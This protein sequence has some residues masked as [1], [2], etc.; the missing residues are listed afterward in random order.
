MLLAFPSHTPQNL[1]KLDVSTSPK[2][3]SLAME[4]TLSREAITASLQKAGF[5]QAELARRLEVSSQAVTNWLKGVDFPRPDKLLKLATLL[6]LSFDQLVIQPNRV[7]PVVAFRKKGGAKTTLA[8]IARAQEMGQMLKPLVPYL[9]GMQTLRSQIADPSINY[10]SLQR[11]V[12]EV[13]FKLG[14][15]D[16]AVLEY[17]HLI[18]QFKESGAVLIPVLWGEK[19]RHENALHIYLPDE[20]VTFIFL[21]LD[22]SM[23]DFKFWMAHELA[24]VFT[25]CLAGSEAGED[26]ADAFAG[27]LLFPQSCAKLAYQDASRA[28]TESGIIQAL[29]A[30]SAKYGISLYSVFCETN[31]F[32]K[33]NQLAPLNVT[34]EHI[35]AA[36]F[37]VRK[38][39]PLI[40]ES[41]FDPLPPNP[42]EYIN[43]A[44]SLFN[45]EFFTALRLMIRENELG[46]SYV[47]QIM[48]I[49]LID[50]S[51]V[52]VELSS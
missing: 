18:G 26:F 33:Q 12:A 42:R 9:Q 5:S 27:A 13:R 3:E 16:L 8:H 25:T 39:I 7:L 23:E 41:L 44:A 19:Q 15:G 34:T 10:T 46:V 49:S 38:H 11:A 21:N 14:L 45:T 43:S 32:A 6:Q 37:A 50:A 4:K 31:H 30:H 20:K 48:D 2:L 22:T 28:H 40:S 47:Q 36:R 35:H 24:H 17:K 29:H 52:H 51:G 1:I